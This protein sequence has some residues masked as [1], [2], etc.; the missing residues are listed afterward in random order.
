MWNTGQAG[1]QVSKA[2]DDERVNNP[3]SGALALGKKH[4]CQ[5]HSVEDLAETR[6]QRR[7]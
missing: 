5:T 6:K 3:A 7:L 2:V 4:E 1:G